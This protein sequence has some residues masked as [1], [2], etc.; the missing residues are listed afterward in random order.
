MRNKY[1]YIIYFLI[2]KHF[3]L[4]YKN[5]SIGFLWNILHPFLYL[6][7]FILIFSNTFSNIDNYPLFVISGLIFWLYFAGGITQLS[8]VFIKN[9]HLIKLLNTPK[10]FYPIAELGSEL[11]S[12]LIGFIPFIVIMFF[13]GFNFTFNILY[14]LPVILLFSIFIFS[15]GII[16][17]SLNIFLRDFGVLW[18]TLNPALFMFSPI[19]YSYD[20]VPQK[21]RVLTGFNPIY[22]FLEIVRDVLYRGVPP[23]TYY[24]INCLIITAITSLLAF[25]VYRLIR[26][27]I[28]FNL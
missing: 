14:I 24:L 10:L 22:H 12:F 4:K 17:G 8:M 25:F 13:Y 26:N 28:I 23:S 18:Q 1:I 16:L 2:Y 3:K 19:A 21:F 20:I 7:V 6:L 5:T 9:A 27:S 15:A 11:I